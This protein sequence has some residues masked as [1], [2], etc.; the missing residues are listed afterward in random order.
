MCVPES[1]LMTCKNI[2]E[3]IML[4]DRYIDEMV[5]VKRKIEDLQRRMNATGS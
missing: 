2:A 1:K 5:E 4:W 3:D